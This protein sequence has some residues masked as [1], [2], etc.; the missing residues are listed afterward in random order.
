MNNSCI[1]WSQRPWKRNW[2]SQHQGLLLKK[3]IEGQKT[4][5]TTG[6]YWSSYKVA[7]K[8]IA[9]HWKTSEQGLQMP[10]RRNSSGSS[11]LTSSLIC[12]FTMS[13]PYDPEVSLSGS[14]NSWKHL[15]RLGR[16][17]W[18]MESS[19]QLQFQSI[20]QKDI[21]FMGVNMLQSDCKKRTC[22]NSTKSLLNF[23]WEKPCFW[24]PILSWSRW[25]LSFLIRLCSACQFLPH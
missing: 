8:A 18:N 6:R 2:T 9:K 22:K 13:P 21:P 23:S 11:Y 24:L 14:E 16:D 20:K 19:L 1:W 12:P 5:V 3:M 25:Y 4:Q 17:L 7:K 10:G 15:K